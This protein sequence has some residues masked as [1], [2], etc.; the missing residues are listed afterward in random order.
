MVT[1]L[2]ER[3]ADCRSV[4]LHAAREPEA[5]RLSGCSENHTCS[6][7]A[8]GGGRDNRIFWRVPY[9]FGF[10]HAASRLL[11]VRG[12]G[13]GLLHSSCAAGVLALIEQRGDGS[14]VVLFVFLLGCYRRRPVE[15]GS[16]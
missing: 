12:N 8:D 3:L 10:V 6:V 2:A 4:S 7:L 16:S 13:G 14:D 15:P 5:V 9:S 11:A 1:A